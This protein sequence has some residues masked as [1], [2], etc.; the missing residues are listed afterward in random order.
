MRN[1]CRLSVLLLILSDWP[2]NPSRLS[3]IFWLSLSYRLMFST[4]SVPLSKHS[5][6]DILYKGNN[7]Q[8]IRT[9]TIESSEL[10]LPKNG[11]LCRKLKVISSSGHVQCIRS[12][13][14]HVMGP[15][16]V[17]VKHSILNVNVFSF[18]NK[19]N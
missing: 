4:I 12:N 1:L 11:E 13:I 5:F 2:G 7:Y 19:T 3:R 8:I 10:I 18:N 15:N 6:H 14:Q 17:T 9:R 16:L